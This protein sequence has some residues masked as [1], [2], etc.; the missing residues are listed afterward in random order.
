[1]YYNF[2]CNPKQSEQKKTTASLAFQSL[3]YYLLP[4]YS[5]STYLYLNFRLISIKIIIHTYETIEQGILA[6]SHLKKTKRLIFSLFRMDIIALPKQNKKF[7]NQQLIRTIQSP[8]HQRFP[9][10]GVVK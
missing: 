6:P 1:M 2:F 5:S 8:C 3:V 10:S 7:S 9:E 4:E